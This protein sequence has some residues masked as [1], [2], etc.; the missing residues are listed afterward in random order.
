[1]AGRFDSIKGRLRG[2]GASAENEA[3][4]PALTARR[5]RLIERFTA[6]QL[7]LGGVLYEMAVRDHVVMPVLLERAAVLQGIETELK[8]AQAAVDAAE[9]ARDAA[10]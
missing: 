7:D 2:S 8:D 3:I 5:D 1:M 10:K 4:D 9:A 6:H